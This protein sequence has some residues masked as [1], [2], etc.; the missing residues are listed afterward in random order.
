M[1]EL[2]WVG[3]IIITVIIYLFMESSWESSLV[4]VNIALSAVSF[5]IYFQYL[6]EHFWLGV[7]LAIFGILL[8]EARII[9]KG[10]EGKLVIE[11]IHRSPK[12]RFVNSFLWRILWTIPIW[13]FLFTFTWTVMSGWLVL[14]LLVTILSTWYEHT[15]LWIY[16]KSA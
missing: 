13:L 4:A 6:E 8:R 1:L 2:W 14:L 10:K 16:P 3:L 11:I 15:Y 9:Q 5:G 12:W 7:G